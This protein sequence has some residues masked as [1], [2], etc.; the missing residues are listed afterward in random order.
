MN[1]VRSN[2]PNLITCLNITSGCIA[3]VF[4]FAGKYDYASVAIIAAAVFDFL[5]GAM[6]R[7]LGAYSEMGKELDSLCDVVSFGLAPAALVYM[8]L[9]APANYCALLIA[10]C[11]AL[12]LARFNVDT[13]QHDGFIGLPIPANALFWIGMTA[14]WTNYP[15]TQTQVWTYAAMTILVALS[16]VAPVSLPSLKFHNF[17][18]GRENNPR[19][20][21]IIITIALLLWLGIS[22][23][24]VVIPIY[25]LYGAISTLASKKLY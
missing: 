18:P 8:Q 9:P 15:P 2:T 16:M 10:V 3:L 20:I 4:A 21:I 1:K 7:A 25:F 11:G 13:R 12:R 23:L 5:D 24:A 17:K 19:F 22:G 6:A 14:F